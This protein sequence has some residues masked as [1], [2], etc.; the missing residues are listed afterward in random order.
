KEIDQFAERR[1]GEMGQRLGVLPF[2]FRYAFF[3]PDSQ[4]DCN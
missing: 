3:L 2:G 1:G 4:S